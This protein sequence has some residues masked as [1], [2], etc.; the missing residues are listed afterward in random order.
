[1]SQAI[2]NTK[3]PQMNDAVFDKLAEVIGGLVET[4]VEKALDKRLGGTDQ[5]QQLNNR[6]PGGGSFKLP[7]AEDHTSKYRAPEGD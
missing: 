3:P 2:H 5:Q 7:K 1:M 4:A 6:K